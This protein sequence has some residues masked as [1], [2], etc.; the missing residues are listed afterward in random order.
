MT[1]D[2]EYFIRMK[3]K[4][5]YSHTIDG[6]IWFDL[7]LG[8]ITCFLFHNLI[9]NSLFRNLPLLLKSRF[10]AYTIFNWNNYFSKH[11]HIVILS[12]ILGAASHIGWDSFTHDSGY[13]VDKM[14]DLKETITISGNSI[15]WFKILQHGSTVLGGAAIVFTIW[16][17]PT[18][19]YTPPPAYF[20]Y[21]SIF[22][23]IML[24]VVGTRMLSGIEILQFGNLVVS[25]IAAA[26]IAL[27]LTPMVLSTFRL[28]KQ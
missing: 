11:W 18:I 4:S 13:F 14:P 3:V 23:L 15:P 17:L 1:P 10:Y 16:K 9:K 2:F 27:I 24:G 8:L 25:L 19:S 6:I 7:P 20:P 21:W 12:I 22:I 28:K 5:S 26:L